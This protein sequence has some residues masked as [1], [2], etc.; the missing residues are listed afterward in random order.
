MSVWAVISNDSDDDAKSDLPFD[1]IS[2][3][4]SRSTTFSPR[5][6]SKMRQ[7]VN[8]DFRPEL[9]PRL[10][11]DTGGPSQLRS[12][13]GT[14]LNPQE[15]IFNPES[16]RM[17]L[18]ASENA[19][20]PS[21]T[22]KRAP[23]S[24]PGSWERPESMRFNPRSGKME[25][26]A[27][28]NQHG[29]SPSVRKRSSMASED[30]GT[31]PSGR[32][33]AA[34]ATA[35]LQPSQ[36]ANTGPSAL[37][38]STEADQDGHPP[39]GSWGNPVSYE[40][41]FNRPVSGPSGTLPM[42]FTL[43]RRPSPPSPQ[44]DER[45]SRRKTRRFLPPVGP[46][47]VQPVPD[48]APWGQLAVPLNR[49]RP[50]WKTHSASPAPPPRPLEQPNGNVAFQTPHEDQ[51]M[52]L[53]GATL[54][55]E[56][57]YAAVQ[58]IAETMR[59]IPTNS[60][61]SDISALPHFSPLEMLASNGSPITA[62]ASRT[63]DV[64]FASSAS[65]VTVGGEQP[66][67]IPAPQDSMDVYPESSSM[68][69]IVPLPSA[70]LDMSNDARIDMEHP[71]LSVHATRSAPNGATTPTPAEDDGMITPSP[72]FDVH[73][74]DSFPLPLTSGLDD[75]LQSPVQVDIV[76]MS[77]ASLQQ[78]EQAVEDV[79]EAV[80]DV[81]IQAEPSSTDEVENLWRRSPSI[82]EITIDDF[83]HSV[84]PISSRL[85]S[86]SARSTRNQDSRH[87]R[88]KR[89]RTM[90]TDLERAVIEIESPPPSLNLGRYENMSRVKWR[91]LVE[92]EALSDID[93]SLDTDGDSPPSSRSAGLQR[94]EDHLN[95][96]VVGKPL[97]ESQL[98]PDDRRGTAKRVFNAAQVDDWN[99]RLPTL[100]KNPALHR[101]IFEAFVSEKELESGGI[102]VANKY[103]GAPPDLEFEYAN[104]TLYHPD[105]PD[106]EL[107]LGCD[108][109]GPCAPNSSTCTCLKRQQAYFYDSGIQGFA[110]DE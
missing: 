21:P 109:N 110:Y 52:G 48:V 91:A 105:V 98:T 56:V 10:A 80:A 93:I 69:D 30:R 43:K 5:K 78:V 12:E 16:G 101:A 82:E 61:P 66:S 14:W 95:L 97:R 94:V 63:E 64:V 89:T 50:S 59:T 42:N 20:H 70:E 4:R 77:R 108:C 34:A 17:E 67:M 22:S 45:I 36:S 28:E 75:P 24:Q 9:T 23:S 79:R 41:V 40:P 107:G 103:D 104:D 55:Q 100:T 102:T 1:S 37:L 87:A 46:S 7:A 96:S 39:P 19:Q 86:R 29:Q 71:A 74:S 106:P 92:R 62:E 88:T 3:Q 44:P 54:P 33:A 49:L 32:A 25:S 26:S 90:S 2:S 8:E 83:S 84:I 76:P 18:S 53:S 11:T 27:S 6:P 85:S 73:P 65:I 31:G 60:T 72:S 81:T 99:R 38:Q 13:S 58:A 15:M 47:F 35:P 51:D 57:P 68:F